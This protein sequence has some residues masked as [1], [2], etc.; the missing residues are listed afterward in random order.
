M[1][2][3]GYGTTGI[4]VAWLPRKRVS[5]LVPPVRWRHGTGACERSVGARVG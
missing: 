2:A 4:E 1:G 5:P 3:S